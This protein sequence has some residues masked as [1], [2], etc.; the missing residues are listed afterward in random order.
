VFVEFTCWCGSQ[1][2]YNQAIV[3]MGSDADWHLV[4]ILR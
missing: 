1:R 4:Q 3:E 2:V